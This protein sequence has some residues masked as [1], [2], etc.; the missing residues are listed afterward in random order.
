M[1]LQVYSYQKPHQQID[2]SFQKAKVPL[3]NFIV[4]WALKSQKIRMVVLAQTQGLPRPV[5]CL[6]PFQHGNAQKCQHKVRAFFVFLFCSSSSKYCL[7]REF[8]SLK[9]LIYL[10]IPDRNFFQDLPSFTLNLSHIL[11]MLFLF[12]CKFCVS[13]INSMKNC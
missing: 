5:L 13:T 8:L 10:L 4:V 6:Q 1:H 12:S 3:M 7:F 2:S 11:S 9:R